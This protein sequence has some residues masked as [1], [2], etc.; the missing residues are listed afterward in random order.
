MIDDNSLAEQE[1]AVMIVMDGHDETTGQPVRARKTYYADSIRL[2]HRYVDMLENT[3]AQKTV[4]N[5]TRFHLTQPEERDAQDIE[6]PRKQE[7]ASSEV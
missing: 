7:M 1:V 5:Y 2:G 6:A 4:L 3:T